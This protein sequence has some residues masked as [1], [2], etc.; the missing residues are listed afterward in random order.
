MLHNASARI[1]ALTCDKRRLEE[2]AAAGAE[3]NRPLSQPMAAAGVAELATEVAG[4][5]TTAAAVAVAA[6]AGAGAAV[7]E[8]LA[9]AR[10]RLEEVTP[11]PNTAPSCAGRAV[12]ACRPALILMR[13]LFPWMRLLP[14]ACAVDAAHARRTGG[15][16]RKRRGISVSSYY[17]QSHGR[18]ERRRSGSGAAQRRGCTP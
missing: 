16:V 14:T 1:K 11:A 3:A 12:S 6:A 13:F 2:E 7:H 18:V 8:E 10:R 9:A 5:D 15:K 17:D 4:A